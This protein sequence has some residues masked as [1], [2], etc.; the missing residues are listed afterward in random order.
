MKRALAIIAGLA[1][2]V[3]CG[4]NA[5]NKETKTEEP[6]TTEAPASNPEAD[7]GMELIAK[8]DCLTCHKVAE[9]SVGPAY[10]AVAGKYADDPAIIDTLAHKVIKGG[11]GNWGTTPMTPHPDLKIEDARAMVTYVLSLK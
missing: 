1:F 5:E 4:N 11:S 9:P 10:E 8:S 3:A 6:A 2:I 7:R